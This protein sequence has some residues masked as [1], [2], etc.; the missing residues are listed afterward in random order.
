MPA[1]GS[2]SCPPGGI[3]SSP[4]PLLFKLPLANGGLPLARHVFRFPD[5]RREAFVFTAPPDDVPL[6]RI[7]GWR[8]HPDLRIWWTPKLRNAAVVAAFAEPAL[9][10]Q[11]ARAGL[12]PALHRWLRLAPCL[13]PWRSRWALTIRSVPDSFSP[14][15]RAWSRSGTG[16]T[17]WSTAA[18]TA[19]WRMR[20]YAPV[21][22]RDILEHAH[23]HGAIRQVKPKTLNLIDPDR[24][25]ALP[26]AAGGGSR[27]PPIR[28]CRHCHRVSASPGLVRGETCMDHRCGHRVHT[29]PFGELAAHRTHLSPRL[30]REVALKLAKPHILARRTDPPAD[31]DDLRAILPPGQTL[32]PLQVRGV[33]FCSRHPVSLNATW[34]GGGKTIVA[35]LLVNLALG[36]RPGR[37]PLP[38]PLPR[39]AAIVP[40]YLRDKWLR[41]ARTWLD[42]RIPA[43][44]VT[45]RDPLPDHG[46]LIASYD[47]ARTHRS[48]SKRHYAIVVC[49]EAQRV[50]NP[51]SGRSRNILTMTA[52]RW[53]FTTGTPIYNRP[54]DLQPILALACPDA[55]A[56]VR[57]FHKSF[58][59]RDPDQ[60]TVD[61][62]RLL[63]SL[64]PF[65]R[66][67]F[68]W[69]PPRAQVLAELPPQPPPEIVPV[70][71]GSAAEIRSRELALLRRRQADPGAS[72]AILAQLQALRKQAALELVPAVHEQAR[73]FD[74]SR[75]PALVFSW[76]VD[77]ARTLHQRAA[78]RGIPAALITGTVP[79]SRRHDIVDDFQSGKLR[80]AYMTFGAGGEGIDMQ[81]AEAV[82][83][84]EFDW[85][86]A[87]IQQAI[88]RAVRI[89]QIHRVR[90][91]FMVAEGTIQ[92]RMAALF[93]SKTEMAADALADISADD[94]LDAIHRDYA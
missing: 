72:T 75:V 38:D 89:G 7:A 80:Q 52:D 43:A 77:I 13:V 66:E 46:L 16:L 69:R 27:Q 56:D 71:I 76:H 65:L 17:G 36:L 39:A 20:A 26:P 64:G 9:V 85:T 83:I 44:I 40:A 30:W 37:P 88:A 12:P 59:V 54:P 50:K 6:L 18:S 11:F 87:V 49:D 22:L 78:A 91:L 3:R 31:L 19:A 32:R 94:V 61:E 24:A 23:D 48:L 81:R 4:P 53:H 10:V 58:Q 25:L 5:A 74:T 8:W 57:R 86:P 14:P 60:P 79:T 41:E 82:I 34:M 73:L 1:S 70:R 63:D 28:H 67:T 45:S 68:M 90:T 29:I 51:L 47:T 35:C 15:D 93:A 42:P 55:F 33:E 92:S 2:P 84:A 62:R 21:P